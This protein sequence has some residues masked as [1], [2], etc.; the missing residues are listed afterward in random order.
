MCGY[1]DFQA[2]T[3]CVTR[4]CALSAAGLLT[5]AACRT[6]SF[7]RVLRS[8]LRDA[9]ASVYSRLSV[10][11]VLGAPLAYWGARSLAGSDGRR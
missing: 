5:Y 1:T 11:R 9:V 10:R 6:Q 8:K 4:L 7:W 2:L 3:T